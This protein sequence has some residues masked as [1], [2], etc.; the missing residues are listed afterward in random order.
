MWTDKDMAD[1]TDR[2]IE[3]MTLLQF[4]LENNDLLICS[5]IISKVV[6]KFRYR[7]GL[8]NLEYGHAE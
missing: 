5:L 8:S 1:R 3:F 7:V 4:S 6:V 2:Q